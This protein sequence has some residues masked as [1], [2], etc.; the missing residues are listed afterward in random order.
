MSQIPRGDSL[1]GGVDPLALLEVGLR[2]SMAAHGET[3]PPLSVEEARAMLPAYEVQ[4][5]IGQGG[6]GSVFAAV[7]RDLQRRVAIKVLSPALAE[8]P[9]LS[10]RFRHESRLMASLQHPGVVQVYEAGETAEGH[11][12]Y[13][14]EFVDGEDLA[15]RLGRGKLSLEEAVPLLAQVAEALHAAHRLG[16]VHRD[17]KPAN[18]FLS[19]DGPPRLGDFG[20]ALTAEQAAEA[21]RLTRAGTT[22]GTLEYA[23][24]EQLSRAHPVSPASDVFSLGVLAYEVL[25]GELPRGNFDPPS[26]RNPEVDASFDSVVLRALQTDPARRYADAG[27]FREAFLH[28]AD[29]PR[30]QALRDQAMRRKMVRR[31]RIVAALAVVS[32]LTGGSAVLAWRARREAELR[33]AAAEVAEQRMTGLLQFLLTDLRQRLEPTGNLGAM[34]SVMEK[35][36]EQFRR[37]HEEAGRSPE[38]ALKLAD[39]LVV[40]GDVIGVRG[41]GEAADALYSEALELSEMARAASPDNVE[42]TLR[43]IEALRSRTQHRMAISR[44]GNALADARLMLGE[45]D[46]LAERHQG[47]RITHARAIAHRAI[48]H[49][50]GYTGDLEEAGEE[51]LRAQAIL[52]NLVEVAPEEATY[53]GELADLD[54]SLG[55]NAEA[56]G[57]L[58]EMLRHFAA[59]HTFVVERYGRDGNMYSHAAFRMGVAFQKLGRAEEALP[60]LNDALRI[61]E[62]EA[63]EMPGHKGRLNHVSWCVRFLAQSYEDLGRTTEAAPLRKREAEVN[64]LLSAGPGE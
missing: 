36:V 27:E 60:Y 3:G 56:R 37:G 55:S 53:S 47:P 21:L 63:A 4:R 31:A 2:P 28:A 49:A 25:T 18:I 13:A 59:F 46:A 8:T 5:M 61:A 51:Y 48:A 41:K 22:V 16:I 15:S 45:A 24:P 38:S 23:A 32:L 54:M 19:A 42:R 40:K 14:M 20:L 30:Q 64:A 26:L 62:R 52:R 9:G 34:E 44:Y 39:V 11:L 35:A 10:A 43:V 29:R 50:L 1:P 12:Y 58:S 7:Q 17:V 33:R 57:D 6:M